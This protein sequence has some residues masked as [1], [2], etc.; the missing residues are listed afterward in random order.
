MPTMGRGVGL[1]VRSS[2]KL[3]AALRKDARGEQGI[4]PSRELNARVRG[5]AARFY[6]FSLR[7]PS[8]LS[9]FDLALAF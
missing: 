8:G 6:R 7:L 9:V 3:G 2:G 1:A 4:E 5:S